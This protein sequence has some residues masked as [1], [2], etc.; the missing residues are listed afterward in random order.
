M[1]RNYFMF[2]EKAEI[3]L[4]KFKEFTT[5]SGTTELVE[6]MLDMR[7]PK[8]IKQNLKAFTVRNTLQNKVQNIQNKVQ[9]GAIDCVH[10]MCIFNSQAK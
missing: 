4:E 6:Y 9:L 10:V 8:P 1:Y 5:K 7:D 3:L 2:I